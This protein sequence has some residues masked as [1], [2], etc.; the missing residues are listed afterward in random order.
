MLQFRSLLK[1]Y[2]QC[3][4]YTRL[5]ARPRDL[6]EFC[7]GEIMHLTSSWSCSL[8]WS[9]WWSTRI[10]SKTLQGSWSAVVIKSFL[11]HQNFVQSSWQRPVHSINENLPNSWSHSSCWLSLFEKPWNWNSCSPQKHRDENEILLILIEKADLSSKLTGSYQIPV[12]N[13]TSTGQ[14]TWN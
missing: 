7:V 11:Q 5:F 6:F 4:A 9:M 10:S 1:C 3:T 12:H 13:C 14:S 8:R 2:T